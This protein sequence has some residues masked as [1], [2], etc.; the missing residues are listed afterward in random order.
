M[1][2]KQSSESGALV[3]ETHFGNVVFS[4]RFDS[5]NLGRVEHVEG[6][7][8]ASC[9][10]P[11]ADYEFNV[12]TKPDCVDTEFE[13]GNRSWFYFSVRGVPPGKLLKMNIMNLNKQS[14]LYSQG[15][16]PFVRTSPGKARWERVRERP[17]FEMSENQF[18]L[19]FVHRV[20]DVRGAVTY[21]AFCYP[22]SYTECRDMLQQLDQ[23]LLSTSHT[24]GPCSPADGLYYHRE[25]LCYSL[26]GHRV[27]LLTVTSCHGMLEEREPRLNKL[28][29]DHSTLRPHRFTGKRVFF[30]SSRV[31]PG[32]TPSSFVFNGFLNFI[33]NQDDPR[34]QTLRKMFVFKL[35]PMLN[36]DGVVRGHYRTD[37]RGVN[38]NRQYM[39]PSAELHPSI[40]GA[41]SLLLY[42]HQHNRLNSNSMSALK[43]SNQ[44]NTTTTT[45]PLASEREHYLNCRNEAERLEGPT[46][47][48]SEIP[49]QLEERERW[50][51]GGVEGE[52]GPCDE[53]ESTPS[54]SEVPCIPN[55]APTEQIP[56]HESG[57]AYYIDLHG[58][59]SKRGCFMYGNN[60]ADE[61]QQVE[62]LMYPKLISLNCAHFDFLGCNFSER[63]MYARDRRDGQSKEGSG[64]V[65]I[66]K[67]IGLVHSYTLECNYNTGRSVNTI[68]PACHDNGRATPPPPPAFPP[69]Y[70]PEVYEQVGR[71][72]AIAALDMAECNPW[73]RLVL[74]EHSSLAN[75]R[76]SMLKHV[77]NSKGLGASARRNPHKASS[78]P[79]IPGLSSS[80]SENSL[81]RS[82]GNGG[83]GNGTVTGNRQTGS[84][85]KSSPSFTF[86][87]SSSGNASSAHRPSHKAPGPVRESKAQE[88][89]RPHH[90]SHRLSLRSPSNSQAVP[91]CPPLSPSSSSSSS[92]SSP[93]SSSSSGCAVGVATPPCSISTAGN[94]S[95]DLQLASRSKDCVL[96]SGR[97]IRTGK[98]GPTH[99]LPSQHSGRLPSQTLKEG[100]THRLSSIECSR[101][102]FH[103]RPSRIPLW[104]AG[105]VPSQPPSLAPVCENPLM[106]VCTLK[107][108]I[109]RH[110]TGKGS[111]TLRLASRALLGNSAQSSQ[112][113]RVATHAPSAQATSKQ[114]NYKRA[115]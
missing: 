25:L 84:Q 60:L 26:D 104:T 16:A 75:L 62:N 65:A 8:A 71:A 100:S 73:S 40:Y 109:R 15:M 2:V 30:L 102:E 43:S 113:T 111:P 82:R 1:L 59:A 38:L 90:L 19:S 12:W 97:S 99:L 92:S 83:P 13:N 98:A 64:R 20:L 58:H 107:P 89:R 5:G 86:G 48:L 114:C 31:H 93:P 28:F 115:V 11:H 50:E 56:P 24:L 79:K 53:N 36:P 87:W 14:R 49:M 70:T 47:D 6:Q 78:P 45:S 42:H 95:L 101:C 4:S 57:V 67:A 52:T 103:P 34:A 68:P 85:L 44:S 41:K 39:N 27:D 46:L 61:V 105:C 10:L 23:R 76:A 29:P 106:T 66:H 96:R 18:T 55:P 17:T 54:R 88:K 3:M 94:N 63:N 33:L 69:K 7:G 108:G 81:S 72:V 91:S 74:S 32:E 37:S 9:A 77:R 21:F 35:I 22:F 51:K 112:R 110:L 80:V